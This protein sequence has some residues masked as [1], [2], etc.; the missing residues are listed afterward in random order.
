MAIT[1]MEIYLAL[2]SQLSLIDM[3]L[4]NNNLSG[5]LP[6]WIWNVSN[7]NALAVS[8]NQLKGIVEGVNY[9]G[10]TEFEWSTLRG[11]ESFYVYLFIE[12]QM[13]EKGV[14]RLRK[15]NLEPFLCG[16]PLHKNCSDLDSPPTAAPNTSNNEDKSGLMD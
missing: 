3:D 4:S 16:P 5:E 13:E 14:F 11:A 2:I 7:L 6:R 15:L 9:Y 12:N 8:N 10:M 1:L